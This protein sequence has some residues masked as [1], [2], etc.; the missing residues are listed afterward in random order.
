MTRGFLAVSAALLVAAIMISPAMAYTVCSSA[1]PSYTIGSGSPYQYTMGSGGLQAYTI[2]SGSPYQYT[3]GSGGLQAYTIGSGSP[4]QYTMGSAAFQGYS[5]GMG[6]PA[7]SLGCDVPVP[8]VTVP[9]VERPVTV[10]PVVEEPVVDEPVV[11]EPV[12][13]EPVV[14]EPVVDEPVVEEP[15]LMNIV[16]TAIDAGNFNTLVAAVEAAGLAEV[17]SGDGPFT[18]F[19]PTDDAFARLE[20]LDE[21]DNETLAE[22]LKYHVAAGAIMASDVV[23]MT[24]IPTLQ[25]GNLTVEVTEEGVTVD[26]ANVTATD[27]VCS[28][29]VIHVIDSVLILPEEAEVAAPVETIGDTLADIVPPEMDEGAL[30]DIVIPEMDEGTLGDIV[31]PEM[32]E[33]TLGDIVIPEMDEGT[34]GD[35]VTP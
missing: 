13:D 20:G 3:A 29:G 14:D 25:G 35:I 21:I 22:I 12:V 8:S 26:G 33:G 18:V 34:L 4:Y 9:A 15:A 5:I 6:A 1:N 17:L 2:G 27:I 19:A 31:I 11:D 23:N 7:S 10:E 24:A 28:N 16:E 30:G 32:D